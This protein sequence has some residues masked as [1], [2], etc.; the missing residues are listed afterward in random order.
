[1][2]KFFVISELVADLLFLAAMAIGQL[3]YDKDVKDELTLVDWHHKYL[4]T[5]VTVLA[6]VFS[7]DWKLIVLLALGQLIGWDD[8]V[9]HVVQAATD[10]PW[11]SPLRRV[12]DR[13]YNK[14]AWL[15]AVTTWLDNLFRSPA[16]KQ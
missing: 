13:L 8:T 10:S 3:V 9:Q 2:L 7:A 6:V 11:H 16:A 14:W 4:G 5:L 1:M 12:Y 15:R